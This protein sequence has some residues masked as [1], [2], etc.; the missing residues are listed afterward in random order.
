M[1]SNLHIHVTVVLDINIP[2]VASGHIC[3]VEG[4]IDSLIFCFA[5][6]LFVCQ[7]Q[8]AAVQVLKKG[9]SLSAVLLHLVV[10]GAWNGKFVYAEVLNQMVK[11]KC[12]FPCISSGTHFIVNSWQIE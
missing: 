1:T 3:E 12:T 4:K 5:S 10:H 9:L 7:R 6:V 8:N 2:N 11:R